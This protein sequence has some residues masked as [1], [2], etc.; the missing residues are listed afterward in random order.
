MR[1]LAA[2]L[3][4]AATL[5]GATAQPAHA[6]PFVIVHPSFLGFPPDGD[7]FRFT[8][9][10]FDISTFIDRVFAIE[11]RAGGGC[12]GE[13]VYGSPF[14]C[15][16]GDLIDM[17]IHTPGEVTMGAGTATIN[18]TTFTNVSFLGDFTFAATPSLF[19]ASSESVVFFHQPFVF[20]GTLRGLQ[21]G[22]E[23][24]NIDLTGTGTTARAFFRTAEGT[25]NYQ[26]ESLTA[27]GFDAAPTP[28]PTSLLLVGTGLIGLVARARRRR[29]RSPL[30]DSESRSRD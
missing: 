10:G 1:K 15:T 4:S 29:E 14:N 6:D 16:T 23:V 30:R 5:C 8:G 13:G 7:F 17:S 18:G 24:F 25:Y 26:M 9:S 21:N 20:D 28:E 22:Q 19:P 2:M 11:V 12:L 27:Y 3:M